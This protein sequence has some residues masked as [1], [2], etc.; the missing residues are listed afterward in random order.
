MKKFFTLLIVCLCVSLGFAGCGITSNGNGGDIV[1]ASKGFTEQDI[2]VELLAQQIE[3]TSDLKVDRRTLKGTK[4][5]HEALVAGSINA[6]IEY[7]GTALTTILKKKVIDDPRKVYN[8][9]KQGYEKQFNLEVTQPLGFENTY[10]V[11]VRG[12]DAKKYN[13]ENISEAAKYAPKWDIGIGYEF[14][15]REDGLPGLVKA[16]NLKFKGRPK[17]M[18]LGLIYRALTQGLVDVVVNNSTDGQIARLGLVILKDN[19]KYF[20]PYEAA[21]IVRK[22]TLKKYPQLQKPLSQ[23]AGILTADEMQQLNY[24]VEGELRKVKEVVSEFRQARGL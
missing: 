12:E 19:K 10:A 15:E 13:I 5:C 24:E 18:D 6:Y 20:P 3:A 11:I 1:I 17:S 8:S 16:Y 21:P 14:A 23:I 2:L 4:L 22:E 9:V 7:T